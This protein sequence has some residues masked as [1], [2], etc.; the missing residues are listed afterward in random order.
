MTARHRRRRH[1]GFTLLEVIIAVTIV[2]LLATLVAP[3]VMRFLGIAKERKAQAD[4]N[5]LAQQVRLYLTEKGMT[6]PGDDF[7]LEL[8]CQGDNPILTNVNALNDPWGH[9]YVIMVPPSVNTDFD[10]V[11]YGADGQPGGEGENKDI[12]NGA[13]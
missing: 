2:A 6:R 13:R 5:S 1:R 9:R 4:V 8:L 7:D 3:N 10:V 12:I 11:S